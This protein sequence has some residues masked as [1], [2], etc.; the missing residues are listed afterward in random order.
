MVMA[1]GACSGENSATVRMESGQSF[2]P[3]VL[4]VSEDQS[5]TFVSESADAHTVTA[6]EDRLP[7]GASFFASGG[8]E[9]EDEARDDLA[10]GLLSSG[11]SFEVKFESPGTYQY[12]CIPHE[13]SGMTGR[14]VVEE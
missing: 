9:S 10:G 4:T 13:S 3:E 8:F 1:L 6:Y 2:E 5:V 7:D 14:I 11:E 12:F